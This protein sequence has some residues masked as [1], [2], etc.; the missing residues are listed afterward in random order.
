MRPPGRRQGTSPQPREGG[1]K[2]QRGPPTAAADETTGRTAAWSCAVTDEAEG[3]REGEVAGRGGRVPR[4]GR[5]R[6]LV[7]FYM[8]NIN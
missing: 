1:R 3:G 4:D 5:R 2:G 6:T 7:L 8:F